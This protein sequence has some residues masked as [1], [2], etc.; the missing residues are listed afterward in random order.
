MDD[1]KTTTE[2]IIDSFKTHNFYLTDEDIKKCDAF[3]R[4][5]RIWTHDKLSFDKIYNIYVHAIENFEEMYNEYSRNF[6]LEIF[7]LERIIKEKLNN[8]NLIDEV[9]VVKFCCKILFYDLYNA[10]KD[11][12]KLDIKRVITI[13]CYEYNE[14]YHFLW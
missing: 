11:A 3:V 10:F 14:I 9:D 6:N 8:E 5:L 12:S 13:L 1:L 4:T 2:N 7:D